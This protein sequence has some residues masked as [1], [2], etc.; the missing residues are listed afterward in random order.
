MELNKKYNDDI[1]LVLDGLKDFDEIDAILL[2]GS[3]VTGNI[4][5][6]SDI[7]LYIYLNKEL[8]VDK[9]TVFIKSISSYYEVNNQFWETED[10]FI[11]K[12]SGMKVEIMYRSFSW[13]KEQLDRVLNK[14]QAG[15]GYTTC[16]CSNFLE[17][18]ILLDNTNKFEDL[19]KEYSFEYPAEL[20]KN[21]IKKNIPLLKEIQ[22]SYFNQI[23]LAVRRDDFISINHRV[24]AFLES[25]FDIL[26][27]IN[28]IYHPGEKKLFKTVN[29][30]CKFIPANFNT[31]I[32]LLLKLDSQ[33][34]LET[35]TSLADN[36]NNLIKDLKLI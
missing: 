28:R 15:V 9:R 5:E 25:Y 22:S 13:I 32:K 16:F 19:Q 7:D 31:D 14:H 1:N 2:S 33:T 29:D 18:I 20:Q 4:D 27:A 17:S 6:Y 10:C 12:N 30:R 8:S 11:L 34:V 36:I 23:K 26:F 21:I 35:I 24:S 3:L